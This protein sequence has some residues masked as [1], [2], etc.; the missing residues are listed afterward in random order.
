MTATIDKVKITFEGKEVTAHKL[1]VASEITID[2]DTAWKKVKTYS[3]LE[4]IAKG[5]VKFKFQS[6]D[7]HIPKIWKVKETVTTRM[8][9][10]GFIPFGGLH[11]LHFEKI[12]NENK[13]VQTSEHDS[14]AK[15][16]RH[17]ISMRKV[18]DNT[19]HYTDEIIIYGGALTSVIS[20][21]AKSFFIHRQKRWQLIADK[22]ERN[23]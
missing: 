15:I 22:N 12:D 2:I 18:N 10:Y 19:T 5:K 8:F 17:K 1:T 16:W 3:L 4:F 23:E 14:A 11:T 6:S 21:W 9:I 7:G 20:W 13:F